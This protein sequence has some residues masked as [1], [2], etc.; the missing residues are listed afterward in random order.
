[1]GRL[2]TSARFAAIVVAMVAWV[3]LIVQ[4]QASIGLTG[5]AG[6]ALWAMLRYFTVLA[7]LL[8][9][10]HFTAVALGSRR[11]AR[12]FPLGGTTLAILLVGVV[13]GLLLRGLLELSGGAMLAD[14]LLHKVTPVL[15]PLWWLAFA[16]KGCLKRRDP[17]LWA[18]LPLT[19]FAYALARAAVD[20]LYPYP[21]MDVARLGWGQTLLNALL[22]AAGFL[23]AGLALRWLDGRMAPLTRPLPAPTSSGME[24]MD[25]PE[26]E[27]KQRLTPEQYHVLREGGT[28]R[29]FTGVLYHNHED[30]D[31]RCAA[32]GNELFDSGT[33]FESGSG[34]PSFTSPA[35][36]DHVIL[37]EDNSHGMRRTEVRCAKCGGHLGH[38][39]P[40]GPGPEGLR[41]CINSAALDFEKRGDADGK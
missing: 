16:P 39:F 8:V 38:V 24:K 17:L 4:W 30:G 28:E 2:S 21:F 19:Y 32:C 14:L 40:D 6:A 37:L 26:S 23:A 1:M 9:A 18:L 36:K 10:V 25:L 13:Y 35:A 20:G 27:W 12:P 33:K 34:W 7:N 41:Y 3:G 5:A 29:A 15:V 31:Y 11:A 22:M